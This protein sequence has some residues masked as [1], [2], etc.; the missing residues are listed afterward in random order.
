MKSTSVIIVAAGSGTRMKSSVPKQF[1]TLDN[2][3]I[4]YHTIQ[5][6]LPVADISEIIIVTSSQ[7]LTSEYLRV[8]I[9]KSATIPI[10]TIAGGKRRQDSVYNGL[11]AVNSNSTI[12]CIHDGVRPFIDPETIARTIKLC[13]QYDGAIVAVP[14]T[15]TLKEI[16]DHLIVKTIDRDIIW[17]AQ[18]PQTFRKDI[19]INA[20]K[21]ASRTNVTGT[22]DA[23]LV[24]QIGGRIAIVEGSPQNIKITCRQDLFIAQSTL[25]KGAI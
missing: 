16:Q 4:L 25:E 9:P 5:R 2:N 6:F 12:V 8:S 3:T 21:Q 24:E 19:L 10:R 20:Y 22:D 11:Q 1:L 17:Q 18:T 23:S 15:D 13:D 14:S 7:L